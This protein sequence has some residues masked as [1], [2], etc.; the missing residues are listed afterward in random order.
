MLV[1]LGFAEITLQSVFKD[2]LCLRFV[3][4]C[5]GA[6]AVRAMTGT[7]GKKAFMADRSLNSFLNSSPLKEKLNKFE[8]SI[9]LVLKL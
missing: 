7:V 3:N 4:K 8:V 1:R 6:V 2:K 5:G 9:C